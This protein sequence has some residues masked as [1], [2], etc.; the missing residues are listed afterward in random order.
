MKKPIVLPLLFFFSVVTSSAQKLVTDINSRTPISNVKLFSK[1]GEILTVSNLRG[2]INISTINLA[3]GDSIEI[4]HPD[5]ISEKTSWRDFTEKSESY[6]TPSPITN[7]EEVVITGRK[8]EFLILRG[9]FVSYQIIDNVFQSFSD[10]IIEYSINLKKEK[11]I[12]EEILKSRVFKNLKFIKEYQKKKKNTTF[13]LGSEI[14]PFSFKEEI[15]LSGWD[16]YEVEENGDI[17][18]Q[19]EIIGKLTKNDNQI[20]LSIEYYTPQNPKKISL[21]GMKSEIHNHTINEKFDSNTPEI[22]AINSLAKYYNSTI[23]QKGV[24]INYELIQDFYLLEKK[25]FTPEI[26]KN[27][28]S[29]MDRN[30]TTDIKINYWENKTYPAIPEYLEIMLNDQLELISTTEKK[31]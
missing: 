9:Y 2:E 7:L 20:N 15:L 18:S 14:L 27:L 25:F 12:N 19:K 11:I 8:S 16:K 23:T 29:E 24:T 28:D 5:F 6:L 22:E 4:Y 10:G 13:N 21:F 30:P 3:K 26:F 31:L 1:K 17:K